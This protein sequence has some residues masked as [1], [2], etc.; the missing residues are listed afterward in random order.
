MEIFFMKIEWK[1]CIR[2]GVS[3]FL[4]F[5][6]VKYWDGFSRLFRKFLS[7]A[8]PL[9]LGFAIAYVINILM[10]FYEKR[11]FPR[12]KN[13]IVAKT[14]SFVCMA[15]AFLTL[16]VLIMGMLRLVIPELIRCIS[17]LLVEVPKV[18][19]QAADYIAGTD[20]L[21]EEISR[22]LETIRWDQVIGKGVKLILSGIGDTV[23]FAAGAVSSAVSTLV[24]F[25][26]GFVFSIYVLLG[27]EK[28]K[29]QFHLLIDTYIPQ[30][31]SEKFFYVLHVLNDCFHRYIVGQCTEAVILGSL[32]ALG[33]MI[34][35]FPYA[36]MT[37]AVIGFT[38]LIPVAGAYIGGAV[39]FL[40]ILTVSPLKAFL[41]LLYLVV[42]QQLEGN[43]IYP[44]V[45]GSSLGLPGMWVL[46]AVT[47]GGGIS[48][49][50]GMLLSVPFAA[51]AYRL[52]RADVH[53]RGS[54]K[55]AVSA[56]ED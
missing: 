11:Y 29:S 56:A 41:F 46:A 24:T 45:V 34:F 23:T 27:R 18:L 2:V 43:L 28:L 40:L 22:S 31:I 15:G 38:A 25:F 16:L 26:I 33:M 48:G 53:R 1:S 32:C 36:A 3:L 10:S 52:L 14:R 42:L 5:L 8:W 9:F 21:S 55:A 7:A 30:K 13:A 17:L 12:S 20:L 6:A 19:E 44:R 54:E 51:A 4:L 39:G 47:V 49:V 50:L 35:R 37:G